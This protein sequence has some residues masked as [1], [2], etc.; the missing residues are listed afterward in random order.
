MK[1]IKLLI[2]DD[3]A[4]F[5]GIIERGVSSD[6]DIETVAIATDPYEARDKIIEFAPDVMVCDV[7][8]PKMNGI[9]FIRRLLP[10][11]PIRVIV[12]SSVS[13]VVLDAMNAGA[14]DFVA[15]PDVSIG[16]TKDVFLQDLISKIKVA[17]SAN[18]NIGSHTDSARD[19]IP[20]S[21]RNQAPATVLNQNKTPSYSKKIIAIGAST[22]GTEAIYSILSKLPTDLP[23]IVIVQHIPPVFSRMFAERMNNSTMF[24]VREAKTGDYVE[25][26]LVLVAPGDMHMR[27]KR[28]GSKLRVE[29]FP[30]EKVNGH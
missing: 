30:G 29:T 28:L 25:S 23:G 20:D 22:G 18:I 11:Y 5:R 10:Q 17:A 15:K 2:V 16:R 8:M 1:K 13:D 3:S 21:T 6:P 19:S 27:I 4:V 24:S 26:G 7:V 14:V 12:M 9:E